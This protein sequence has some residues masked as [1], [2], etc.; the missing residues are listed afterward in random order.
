MQLAPRAA[1]PHQPT[2]AQASSA[3]AVGFRVGVADAAN[4]TD[5]ESIAA[6]RRAAYRKAA[7]FEWNDEST[8]DWSTAD[9]TGTVMA[10]WD[11]AGNVLSTIRASVFSDAV[12]AEA[13]LEYSLTGIS[14]PGPALTLS[15]AATAPHA[16]QHGLFALLR[17]A[18]LSALPDTPINSAIAIVYEGAP[19]SGLMRECGYSFFQPQAGWDTEAVART[20]PMLA[21]LP[22]AKFAHSLALRQAGLT[23]QSHPVQFDIAAISQSLRAQCQA[24]A[25]P[26]AANT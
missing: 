17:I 12:G 7:Q 18:Y 11:A 20:R 14:L 9:D 21:V 26:S 24:L 19:H 22:R 25:V 16:A 2:Q 10:V 13:F 5:R 15:R 23:P 3:D 6:L 4:I 8:L 1:P